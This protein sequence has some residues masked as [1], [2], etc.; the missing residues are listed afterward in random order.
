MNRELGDVGLC[1]IIELLATVPHLAAG[2]VG[3]PCSP[4][5]LGAINLAVTGR[6]T[7]GVPPFMSRP[8]ARWVRGAQDTS[9]AEMR[10]SAAWRML[11]PAAA[12]TGRRLERHDRRIVFNMMW[13]S[14]NTLQDTANASGFG[15]LWAD[16][17]IRRGSGASLLEAAEGAQAAGWQA[18]GQAAKAVWAALSFD[19]CEQAGAASGLVFSTVGSPGGDCDPAVMLGQMLST[20]TLQPA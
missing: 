10:D 15:S 18:A 17:A 2:G 16:A 5:S 6:L 11:L 7:D 3:D 8:I 13:R 9:P 19:S 12:N 1:R 20:R 14:Y 4:C